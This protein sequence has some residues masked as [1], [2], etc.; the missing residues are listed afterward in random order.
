MESFPLLIVWWPNIFLIN[1]HLD[2]DYM[3]DNGLISTI[4]LVTKFAIV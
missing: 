4:D 3:I 1:V 2:F